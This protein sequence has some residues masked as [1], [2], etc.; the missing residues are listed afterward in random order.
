[1]I[2]S[3]ILGKNQIKAEKSDFHMEIKAG[4]SINSYILQS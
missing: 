2:L 3:E 4:R 1:M